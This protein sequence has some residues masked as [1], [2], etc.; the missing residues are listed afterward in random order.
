MN[1][2]PPI[3]SP[4]SLAGLPPVGRPGESDGGRGSDAALLGEGDRVEISEMGQLLSTMDPD[5]GTR[6]AKIREIRE[7]I[8]NG[9]YD[10]GKRLEAILD[11]VVADANRQG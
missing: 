9:T 2:I 7:A 8:R 5:N 11:R 4:G 10:V 1:D 3:K 6:A